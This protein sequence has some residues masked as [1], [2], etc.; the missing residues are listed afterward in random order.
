MYI[1]MIY[2]VLLHQIK[3]DVKKVEVLNGYYYR[4]I[5]LKQIFFHVAPYRGFVR[6]FSSKS[7]FDSAVSCFCKK[8]VQ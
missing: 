8:L 2:Y 5:Y 3:G 4:F 1:K 7:L 6:A